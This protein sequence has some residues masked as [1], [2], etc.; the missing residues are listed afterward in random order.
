VLDASRFAD[1]RVCELLTD[2]QAVNLGGHHP[3]TTRDRGEN[4]YHCRRRN[5]DTPQEPSFAYE[6]Y[7]TRNKLVDIYRGEIGFF[8][9]RTPLTI[10]GQPAVRG[11]PVGREPVTMCF[12]AVAL[13]DKQSIE[14]SATQEGKSCELAVAVAERIVR[15]LEG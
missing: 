1:Q 2:E 14:I 9:Q 11:E 3:G 12:V 8:E 4:G 13:S 10:G 7:L 6:L 5:P 15:N